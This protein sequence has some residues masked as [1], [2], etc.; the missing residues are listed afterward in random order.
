MLPAVTGHGYE[1]LEGIEDGGMAMEAYVEAISPR[2][3]SEH[4]P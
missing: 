1:E 3:L 4:S 2:S